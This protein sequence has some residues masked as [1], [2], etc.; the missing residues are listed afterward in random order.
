MDE[1]MQLLVSH[2]GEAGE[3]KIKAFLDS[4][5]E[6]KIYTSKEEHID[7]RY[8]KLKDQHE[9]TKK[10]MEEAKKLIFSF[11]ESAT[12]NDEIKIKMTQY[13]QNLAKLQ[14]ENEKIKLDSAIK[15][16][17]LANK[18]KADDIDYLIFKT[19]SKDVRFDEEGKLVGFDV[20]EVRKNY[21]SHFE[22]SKKKEVVL[23]ELKEGEDI[24]KE[25]TKEEFNR[26]SYAERVKIFKED[27][28]YFEK[29]T[30]G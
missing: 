17:L 23:N 10:E 26:L 7:E 24:K 18:A 29:I 1:L 21:P 6:S 28:S 4:M 16:E 12:E 22:E 11:K 9:L 19:V 13:E 8:S 3:D 20:E 15:L 25:L 5:K 27:K 30:K 14:A 2:F